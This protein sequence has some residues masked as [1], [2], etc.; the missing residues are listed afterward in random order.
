MKS[1]LEQAREAAPTQAEIDE[2]YQHWMKTDGSYPFNAGYI[3]GYKAAQ[4]QWVRIRSEADYPKIGER[5]ILASR[6][7]GDELIYDFVESW[8][9]DEAFYACKSFNDYA[10]YMRIDPYTADENNEH[11]PK[12]ATMQAFER[13]MTEELGVE[14]VDVTPGEEV[15]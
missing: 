9:E 10:A 13:I 12:D 15:G 2:A 4:P 1:K 8:S 6:R 3:A 5:V 14:V 11:R 7:G